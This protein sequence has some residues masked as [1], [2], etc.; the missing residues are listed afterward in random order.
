MTV[1]SASR[2]DAKVEIPSDAQPKAIEGARRRTPAYLSYPSLAYELECS[3][4]T[5]YALVRRGLLPP[6]IHLTNGT[7]RFCWAAVEEKLSSLNC[8]TENVT[9]DPFM[10]GVSNV[11]KKK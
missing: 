8:E 2:A 6:P 11:K 3:V 7:V 9:L 1:H 5:I 4:S 10:L